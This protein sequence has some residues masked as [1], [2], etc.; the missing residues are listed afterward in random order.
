MWRAF[1]LILT[2]V[3]GDEGITKKFTIDVG[4]KGAPSDVFALE[5][6]LE[7]G[8]YFYKFFLKERNL[9]LSFLLDLK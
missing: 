9:N 1:Y 7:K 6:Q 4:E 3:I 8:K 5:L 2:F